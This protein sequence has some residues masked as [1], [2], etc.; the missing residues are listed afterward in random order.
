M[1]GEMISGA[2]LFQTREAEELGDQD[3]ERE[4]EKERDRKREKER[5]AAIFQDIVRQ[6]GTLPT[7][8]PQGAAA[9]APSEGVGLFADVAHSFFASAADLAKASLRLCPAS[10]LS[11]AAALDHAFLQKDTSPTLQVEPL[12]SASW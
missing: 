6:L 1:L 3:R 2:V 12:S 9:A 10:R 4:R 8:P 7:W 11:A 5:D